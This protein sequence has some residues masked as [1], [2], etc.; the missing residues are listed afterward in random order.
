MK[1][2]IVGILKLYKMFVSPAFEV[3]FGHACRQKPTCSEYS[4]VEVQK[5]GVIAG[6]RNSI[7]RFIN[8]NPWFSLPV[9]EKHHS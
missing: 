6:G 7:I 5:R 3:L 1:Y 9:H 8:C 4:I 2:L